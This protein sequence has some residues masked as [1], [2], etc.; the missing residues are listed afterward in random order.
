MLGALAYKYFNPTTP[1]EFQQLF[2]TFQYNCMSHAMSDMILL[3]LFFVRD[4]QEA[5]GVSRA[6]SSLLVSP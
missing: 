3:Q 5:P 1:A 6:R 4:I 2:L